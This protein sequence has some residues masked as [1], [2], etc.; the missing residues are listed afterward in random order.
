MNKEQIR[1]AVPVNGELEEVCCYAVRYALGRQSYA[2]E[3]VI[4]YLRKLL[5]YVREIELYIWWRDISEAFPPGSR[6]LTEGK[7]DDGYSETYFRALWL[8]FLN[9]IQ[10][11]RR[12]REEKEGTI[13]REYLH[14]LEDSFLGKRATKRREKRK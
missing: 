7:R 10:E 12:R 13:P 4:G 14:Q 6:E 11:E 5:P 3:S 8:A 2:V 9:D 1:P